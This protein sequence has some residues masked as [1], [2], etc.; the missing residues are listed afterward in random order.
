MH[1]Q[2]QK[3][4]LSLINRNIAGRT[5]GQKSFTL[6]FNDTELF[7]VYC[8]VRLN[9]DRFRQVK[10]G[11]LF[12]KIEQALPGNIDKKFSL[13]YSLLK[14]NTHDNVTE[15]PIYT[16]RDLRQIPAA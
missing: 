12:M 3:I 7:A 9:R 4:Y 1:D 10:D 15:E 5:K 16:Q 11:I 13:A 2:I 6:R 14:V 8:V